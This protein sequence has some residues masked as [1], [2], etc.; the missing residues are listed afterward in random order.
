MD[1]LSS[2]THPHVIPNLYKFLYSVKHKKD[3]QP[4]LDPI[5]LLCGHK[6]HGTFSKHQLK[7]NT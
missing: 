1:I 3:G 2:F 5:D 4:T 7:K 6:N